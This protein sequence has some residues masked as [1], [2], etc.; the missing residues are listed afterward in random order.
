MLFDHAV[1]MSP[2]ER[3]FILKTFISGSHE[4][5][6]ESLKFI[7]ANYNVIAAKIP[8][9]DDLFAGVGFL[10]RTQHQIDTLKA[11]AELHGPKM[12]RELLDLVVRE[13]VRGSER[14]V[15]SQH[16][17]KDFKEWA[18]GSKDDSEPGSAVSVK[19]INY[20]LLLGIV[21]FIGNFIILK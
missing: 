20:T 16:V 19:A 7:L 21:I 4:S 6:F 15:D 14:L 3:A 9:M 11:I 12:S 8:S 13:S 1:I 17:I 5:V 18:Y 2:E 10:A